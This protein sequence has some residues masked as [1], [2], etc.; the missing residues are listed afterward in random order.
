[1]KLALYQGPSPAGDCTAALARVATWLG[2][3]KAAGAAMLVMPELF[4]PGYNFGALT[5]VT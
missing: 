2:A 4:L 5:E 1:M 3:A